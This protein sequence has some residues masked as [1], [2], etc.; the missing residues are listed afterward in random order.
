M[1]DIFEFEDDDVRPVSTHSSSMLPNNSSTDLNELCDT[2]TELNMDG[3]T[4]PISI[5]NVSRR[6]SASFQPGSADGRLGQSL[7]IGIRSPFV[8][9]F[10]QS[11]DKLHKEEETEKHVV[12]DEPEDEKPR[13]MTPADF[14]QLKVLGQGTYGKVLLV[15]ERKTG[16][17]FAQKQL[18]KASMVVEKKHILQ[19]MT[20]R[21]ILESVR[22]PYIVRLFYAMQ[23]H[24]K[25]YLILEYAQGGELFTYL[26]NQ[27]MLS[28]DTVA[29]YLAE[30]ILALYHLHVNVGVVY[31]DLKP[32]NCLLDKEGHLV[33]TDF[34]LSKVATDSDSSCKTILGTPE[35]MAPEI[36]QGEEYD[37]AVDWW[38]LGAVAYDLLTGN[39]PFPGNDY[40]SILQKIWRTKRIDFPFYLTR[41]AQHLISRFLTRDP[42]KRMGYKDID[43]IKKHSF[44]SAIDWEKL[45]RRDKSIVPP[46]VP[47]ITDPELAENFSKEFTEM[48]LSPPSHDSPMAIP[49]ASARGSRDN[50]AVLNLNS[51]NDVGPGIG[52]NHG[53]PGNHP[54][55]GFSFTASSSFIDRVF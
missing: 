2:I 30:M 35:Y 15:R 40:K 55:K 17:L 3:V 32:E 50:L 51:G 19:T 44:F 37:Y 46:I 14:Q 42:K 29:F 36:L 18:K 12:F 28:E 11:L 20:E 13:K 48:P 47:L 54:F 26:A 16:R 9:S 34:G 7:E 4:R 8:S 31:R 53:E 22:H 10:A 21:D 24:E 49:I 41:D 23:D 38:S 1:A 25:L 39:P 45:E 43:Y 33:L 6:L 52:D 5:S 27:V